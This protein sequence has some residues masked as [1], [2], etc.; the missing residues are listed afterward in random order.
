MELMTVLLPLAAL[1]SGVLFTW[2]LMKGRFQG[3][4]AGLNAQL[5]EKAARCDLLN[6]HTQKLHQNWPLWMG[7]TSICRTKIM[8]WA[9]VFP[10]PKSRLPICRKKRRNR[11]G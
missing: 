5:A 9:T 4:F 10:Q 7:N 3:E 8:L 6:R 2:L 1:V 11:F